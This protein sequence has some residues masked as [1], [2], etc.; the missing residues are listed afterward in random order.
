MNE[1]VLDR[2]RPSQRG[3]Q[4][5]QIA[6]VDCDIHP[7]PRAPTDLLPFLSQRWR[8]HMKSFGAHVRQGL[9]G[10]E[11]H[12]RMMARGMRADAYP[13]DGPPGSS[14]E[15]MQAQHLDVNGVET[16]MM[17]TL[18]TNVMEERNQDYAA[19]LCHA[20]NEWQLE[21]WVSREPRLRASLIV[22]QEDAE[23][24]ASEID[25][26]AGDPRIGQIVMS[27]KAIEPLG[28]K[29]YWPIFAAAER[30]R[31]PVAFHPVIAGGG[32]PSA[33]IGWPTYYIQDHYTFGTVMQSVVTSLVFEGVFE[34]FPDLRIVLAEGGFTWVPHLSWRMDKHWARMRAE[35]PHLKRKPSDYLREHFWF[36]TQPMEETEDPSHLRDVMEWVGWNR[37]LFSSDYPH[38]DFDDPRHA[39]KVRL[40]E[41]EK[42]MIFRD[43]ARALYRLA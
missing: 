11:P 33:G 40:S 25:K 23:T 7:V 19:A 35:V 17:I 9:V 18:G 43:N 15:L 30:A 38:W 12:P 28:R 13:P 3:A 26:R 16:G 2:A 5:P 4:R 34:R 37:L 6:V 8:D 1:A 41:Q 29:R 24:A 31:W 32:H 36:T 20:A 14:L 27:P 22:P 39:F 42:A 10:Q 21:A